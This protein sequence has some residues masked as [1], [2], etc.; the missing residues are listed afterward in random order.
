MRSLV[1]PS[2]G[3]VCSYLVFEF[4][5]TC[6]TDVLILHIGSEMS[7]SFVFFCECCQLLV[8]VV[9]TKKEDTRAFHVQ[10]RVRKN[11]TGSRK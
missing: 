5:L 1:F 11:A 6:A 2:P 10:V 7:L 3:A 4:W 8:K 9:L